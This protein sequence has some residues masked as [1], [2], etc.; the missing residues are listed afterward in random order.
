MAKLYQAQ[1]QP[2]KAEP[3]CKRAVAIC[4]KSLGS[5]HSHLATCLITLAR[6]YIAQEKY[7]DA[8]RVCKQSLSIREKAFGPVHPQVAECLYVLASV[9]LAQE[10]FDDAGPLFKQAIS[11]YEKAFGRIDHPQIADVWEK[12]AVFLR[13]TNR[14]EE[15]ELAE[16]LATKIKKEYGLDGI[17]SLD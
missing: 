16:S 9:D 5:E 13:K 8:E 10:K 1:G 4:E 12:Y 17:K 3:F 14:L 7:S 2:E 15:A 11:I 6:I